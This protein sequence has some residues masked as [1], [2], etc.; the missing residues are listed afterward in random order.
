MLPSTPHSS[1]VGSQ[2]THCISR[3]CYSL[4]ELNKPDFRTREKKRT[5]VRDIRHWAARQILQSMA[6][7]VNIKR[8][9]YTGSDQSHSVPSATTFVPL[10]DCVL[11]KFLSVQKHSGATRT[12]QGQKLGACSMFVIN[13]IRLPNKIQ[14]LNTGARQRVAREFFF[15]FQLISKRKKRRRAK[16]IRQT[17]AI[18]Y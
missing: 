16:S 6:K 10:S 8:S 15:N 11:N 14:R 18:Y 12:K 17:R 1:L 13:N 9:A 5:N 3:P 7:A 4:R 2:L